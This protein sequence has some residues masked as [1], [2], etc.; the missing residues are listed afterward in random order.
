VINGEAV[1]V[2][3]DTVISGDPQVND[4]VWVSGEQV[5]NLL[6]ANAI[7]KVA[8]NATEV[9]VEFEGEI[10]KISLK[11]WRIQDVWVMVGPWT[12]V[13][14]QQ[15]IGKKAEV[16]AL[17]SDNGSLSAQLIRV[18]EEPSQVV[19]GA[20]VAAITSQAD[21][22]QAWDMLVFP[23]APWS[24]PLVTTVEVDDNALVDESRAVAQ[25]G[26][27]AEVQAVPLDGNEYQAGV[28]RLEQPVSVTI[29][30][31][32]QQIAAVAS[33]SDT[34]WRQIAG[35]AVWIPDQAVTMHA[36]GRNDKAVVEG[37]LLGNGVI[38]ATRVRF[39]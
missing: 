9:P 27:W 36:A 2:G 33:S 5:D 35:R 1:Q 3:G 24:D 31:D 22:S 20:M 29:E 15:A 39:P 17:Q 16:K 11:A 19:L 10:T 14:G 6:L 25:P 32:L 4:L 26:Q 38:W 12:K 18:V 34:N 28:I 21:G 7:D 13:I 8:S 30:G 37:L 23:D